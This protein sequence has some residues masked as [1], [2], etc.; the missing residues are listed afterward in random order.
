MVGGERLGV[1][2]AGRG[3]TDVLTPI[4]ALNT[5]WRTEVKR[6]KDAWRELYQWIEREGR[7]MLALRADRRQWLVVLTYEKFAQ[8]AGLVVRNDDGG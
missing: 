8:L 2:A 1:T 3:E 5:V 6:R 7:D 4:P